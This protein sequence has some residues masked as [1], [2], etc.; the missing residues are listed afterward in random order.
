MKGFVWHERCVKNLRFRF[1]MSSRMCCYNNTVCNNFCLVHTKKYLRQGQHEFGKIHVSVPVSKY[2][3]DELE[4]TQFN[5]IWRWFSSSRENKFISQCSHIVVHFVCF[6]AKHSRESMSV[7]LP[8]MCVSMP[9][10]GLNA[11]WRKCHNERCTR[12]VSLRHFPIP[13]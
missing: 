4:T 10:G 7:C 13:A 5:L 9:E 3:F 12:H 2:L 1:F 8:Y 6:A 11:G